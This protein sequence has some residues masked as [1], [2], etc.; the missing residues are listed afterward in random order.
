MGTTGDSFLN[1]PL[2][3]KGRHR[4]GAV[5]YRY[6]IV[7]EVLRRAYDQPMNSRL[8]ALLLAL[9]LA[10]GSLAAC[11]GVK[12]APELRVDSV[13]PSEARTMADQF[14]ADLAKMSDD[15]AMSRMAVRAIEVDLSKDDQDAIVEYVYVTL[16]PEQF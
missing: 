2:L 16:C 10:A 4:K 7:T 8:A 12:A 15:K 11:G 14:C 5:T 13:S 6:L 9:P 1:Y 3:V